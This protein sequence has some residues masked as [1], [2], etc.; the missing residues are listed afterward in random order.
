LDIVRRQHEAF[1][2]EGQFVA[3]AA[4]SDVEWIA[5][6]EDPD[7]ATHRGAREIQ[8]YF[9]SWR[10]MINGIRVEQEAAIE[11]DDVVFAWI[12]I[13]GKGAESGAPVEMEQ[14]QVW[15]F[16]DGKAER[17]E[18]YF[19]RAEGRRAAGLDPD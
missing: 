3:E 19:D 9:D 4:H 18:E 13:T 15:R 2:Q 5:A 8:R 16:R 11:N 14:A 6:R 7:A 10:G 1:N 12:R 17:V